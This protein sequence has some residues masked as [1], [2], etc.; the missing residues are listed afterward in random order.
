MPSI[1]CAQTTTFITSVRIFDNTRKRDTTIPV[2]Y[3]TIS[4]C[5][6]RQF[7]YFILFHVKEVATR[8]RVRQSLL[9]SMIVMNFE[10]RESLW[11]GNL[12]IKSGGCENMLP[13]YYYQMY[14]S[15]QGVPL[16]HRTKAHLSYYMGSRRSAA[17]QLR[18][19]EKKRKT[20]SPAGCHKK[21]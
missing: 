13:I 19:K 5:C 2:F 18:K 3:V 14:N 21:L 1:G 17:P 15:T 20:E 8:Q 12:D 4:V 9:L 6:V 11:H 10:V 16:H 7:L